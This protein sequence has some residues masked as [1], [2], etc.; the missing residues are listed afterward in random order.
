MTD[1]EQTRQDAE[2][3]LIELAR[4]LVE[5]TDNAERN[6]ALG[7]LYNALVGPEL[8]QA[9]RE[10]DE[11]LVR[12]AAINTEIV[13]DSIAP[14]EARLAK[15]PALVEKA[16]RAKSQAAAPD[17]DEEAIRDALWDLVDSTL[18][19]WEQE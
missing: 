3:G 9:E 14:L 2:P 17:Y 6:A 15:V 16:K 12:L 19:A 4:K 7:D 18:A 11:A 13:Q 10:R 8:E 1:R 5:A